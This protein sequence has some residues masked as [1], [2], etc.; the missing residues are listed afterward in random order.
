MIKKKFFFFFGNAQSGPFSQ[1]CS[2]ILTIKHTK[3]SSKVQNFVEIE[4]LVAKSSKKLGDHGNVA[5]GMT[6]TT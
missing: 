5:G 1:I 3:L 2:H 4:D 6:I